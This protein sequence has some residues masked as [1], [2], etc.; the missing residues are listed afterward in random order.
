MKRLNRFKDPRMISARVERSDVEKF[1]EII[2]AQRY[3]TLQDFIN[4]TIKMF[5]SGAIHV[6]GKD[7]ALNPAALSGSNQ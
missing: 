2:G 7:F 6:E 1:E 4:H 3:V 5:I